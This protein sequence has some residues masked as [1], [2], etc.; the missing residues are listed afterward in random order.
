MFPATELALRLR[1]IFAGQ[2]IEIAPFPEAAVYG[3]PVHLEQALINLIKNG[4]EAAPGG[5]VQLSCHAQ[6]GRCEF[7][8]LDRGSGVGNQSNLFVPFYTTKPEGA[9]IGLVLCRQIA[10]KHHGQVSLENRPD[11][12]GAL[13]ILAVPL[14]TQQ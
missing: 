5:L 7:R 2:P 1:R 6:G 3:D 14:P 13:A 4:M 11:G 10:A 12:P 8:I 9:G